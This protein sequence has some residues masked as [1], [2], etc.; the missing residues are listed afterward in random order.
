MAWSMVTMIAA[1]VLGPERSSTTRIV[2]ALQVSKG[3]PNCSATRSRQVWPAAASTTVTG[4]GATL[5][6]R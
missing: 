4:I 6:G 1:G 3:R 5:A 2:G